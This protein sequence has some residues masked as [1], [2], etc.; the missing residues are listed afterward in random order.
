MDKD[1]NNFKKWLKK[2]GLEIDG[3][4]DDKIL[5]RYVFFLLTFILSVFNKLLVSYPV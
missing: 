5:K 3:K 2:F 1:L 4:V